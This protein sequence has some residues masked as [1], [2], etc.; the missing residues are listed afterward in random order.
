MIAVRNKTDF[1]GS[2]WTL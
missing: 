1:L 2:P